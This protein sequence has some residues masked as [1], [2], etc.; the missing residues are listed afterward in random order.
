MDRGRFRKSIKKLEEQFPDL[1]NEGAAG[2]GVDDSFDAGDPDHLATQQCLQVASLQ[3]LQTSQDKL[4][5][6]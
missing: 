1:D 2:R 6:Q 4:N 3:Q 5:E